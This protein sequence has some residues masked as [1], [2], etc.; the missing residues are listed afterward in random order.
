[1]ELKEG[2]RKAAGRKERRMAGLGRWHGS[3]W[4][5]LQRTTADSTTKVSKRKSWQALQRDINYAIITISRLLEL[6][7]HWKWKLYISYCAART[8]SPISSNKEGKSMLTT[9]YKEK[10]QSHVS[11]FF[12]YHHMTTMLMMPLIPDVQGVRFFFFPLTSCNSVTPAGCP[13]N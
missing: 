13:T 6:V 9:W 12:S 11:P 8:I 2:R 10:T 1:M 4:N 3:K 5:G 7:E